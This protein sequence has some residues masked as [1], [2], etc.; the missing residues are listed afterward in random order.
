[1]CETTESARSEGRP[2]FGN[3]SVMSV[4]CRKFE[5]QKVQRECTT[6]TDISYDDG[7]EC[8]RETIVGGRGKDGTGDGEERGANRRLTE[9]CTL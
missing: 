2:V 7:L 3:M 8:I 5:L 4:C 1:M 6:G 9:K